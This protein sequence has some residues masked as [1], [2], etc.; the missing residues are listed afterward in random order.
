MEQPPILPAYM[1]PVVQQYART[2]EPLDK[3]AA[4]QS[5][6]LTTPMNRDQAGAFCEQ[7]RSMW[8]SLGA[9]DQEQFRG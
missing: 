2:G 7:V 6:A 9:T 1:T 3:V 5:L 4:V 8:I